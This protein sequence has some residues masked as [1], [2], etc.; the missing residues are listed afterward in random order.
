MFNRK[1]LL[2]TA[3]EAVMTKSYAPPLGLLYVA[4]ALEKAD[5]EVFIIDAYS[6]RLSI[7]EIVS[8]ISEIEPIAFGVTGTTENRFNII[9]LLNKAKEKYKDLLTFWGGPH[10]TLTCSDAIQNVRGVD[11]IIK[12]EGELTVIELMNAYI[13]GDSFNK[14]NGITYKDKNNN[15]IDTPSKNR[16]RDLNFLPLPARHLV[17]IKRYHT[18]LEGENKTETL[19]VISSRGCPFD[20][21]FC[22]NVAIKGRILRKR[23]PKLFV[24]EIEFLYNSYGLRGYDFWDDTL[25]VDKN[26]IIEICNEIIRRKLDIVW[27]ARA[28]ADYVTEKVLG[29]MRKAGC[30]TIGYGVESG[31]ERILK[32]IRKGLILE[33]VKHTV[34]K[35]A[36]MGFLVRC[37][38]IL[39]LPGETMD[40]IKCTVEL[41]KEFE[42]YKNNIMCSYGFAKIYPGTE[43]E[44]EAKKTGYFQEDFSWNQYCEFSK[45]KIFEAN[46]TIPLFENKDLPLEEIKSYVIK[47]RTKGFNV[48]TKG[49][50]KIKSVNNYQDVK[51]LFNIV[52][53][54]LLS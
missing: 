45:S 1:I 33:Q 29:L 35:S 7:D 40:D 23:S 51:N 17:N 24:D 15:I 16:I 43:L 3:P 31:S 10:A 54:Y 49:I 5:F 39:S 36:D 28:R 47:N 38:F 50:K 11:V 44:I 8:K 34:K 12:G 42:S 30:V 18:L 20:C 25:T 32:R 4:A 53:N 46:P 41:I 14:I 21:T 9:A 26:H 52:K 19:G 48:L 27:Y 6:E 13:K 2:S 22:A 37:F